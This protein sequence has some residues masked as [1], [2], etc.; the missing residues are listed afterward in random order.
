MD[1]ETISSLDRAIGWVQTL[2]VGPVATAVAIIAVA[3]I[4]FGMLQGRIDSGK[5]ARRLLGCFILFGASSIAT[6]FVDA[7]GGSGEGSSPSPR[8]VPP[9][10]GP[11]I[12]PFDPY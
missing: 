12:N 6:A 8:V 10:N 2:L 7:G 5:A 3:S 4:G 9:N 11:H 1:P